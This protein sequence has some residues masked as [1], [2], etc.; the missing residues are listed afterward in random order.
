[1]EV[2]G[3][4]QRRGSG[5]QSKYEFRDFV[6]VVDHVRHREFD[7]VS[8]SVGLG[9]VVSPDSTISVGGSAQL[10]A[11]PSGGDGSYAYSWSPAGSL[12]DANI[13]DPLASPSTNTTFTVTVSDGSGASATGQVTV[14]VQLEAVASATPDTIDDGDTST[15]DVTAA[16]GDGSYTY[17]WTADDGN[18]PVDNTNQSPDVTPSASTT[19]TVVVTDGNGDSV[20]SSILVTVNAAAPS[21]PVA[22]WTTNVTPAPGTP[23]DLDA[24]CS[25]ASPGETIT[26]IN[27][28]VYN[29]FDP[30]PVFYPAGF[31]PVE[32]VCGDPATIGTMF[33]YFFAE[34]TATRI[35]LTVTDS[36]GATNS[37]EVIYPF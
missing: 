6:G 17:L 36:S 37:L 18:D 11:S 12:D 14:S 24:S 13:A 21:G 9:L 28:S 26:C 1:M 34:S 2:S 22:C 29:Q 7:S 15:L 27:F 19:Y 32:G 35:T 10:T 4:T 3:A 8:V 25:T 23:V 30:D 5:T 31:F 16:G 20:S 33:G